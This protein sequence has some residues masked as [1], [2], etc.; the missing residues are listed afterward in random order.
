MKT[1]L[2]FFLSFVLQPLIPHLSLSLSTN[3]QQPTT[4][5]QQHQSAPNNA[6]MILS[7]LFAPRILTFSG[8]RLSMVVGS[9]LTSKRLIPRLQP[10]IVSRTFSILSKEHQEEELEGRG[11]AET[12]CRK[13]EMFLTS[14]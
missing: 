11:G 1:L 8:Q 9:R 12:K 2:S 4:N 13:K 5:N 3:N 7:R 10:Q 6:Q 14:N